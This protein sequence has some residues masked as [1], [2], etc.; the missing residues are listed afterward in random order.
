MNLVK[1]FDLAKCSR[2][3]VSCNADILTI[4]DARNKYKDCQ[5]AVVNVLDGMPVWICKTIE[6]AKETVEEWQPYS[7]MPL[8][9]VDLRK[10]QNYESNQSS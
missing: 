7:Y 10:E 2:N 8:E 3:N 5:H 9:I 1:I 6:D 4:D